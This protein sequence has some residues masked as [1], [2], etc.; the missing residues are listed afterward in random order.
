M[1]VKQIKNYK[2][3]QWVAE[4]FCHLYLWATD[5]YAG[6]ATSILRHWGFTVKV[7]IVWIKP[8]IRMGNYFRHQHELCFFATRGNKRLKRNDLSTIFHA[9]VTIH[10]EK[11]D[12]FYSLVESASFENY[13]DI[14]ARK[15]RAGWDV[16]GN[17]IVAQ[18]QL[19]LA[20]DNNSSIIPHE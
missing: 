18:Y 16:V 3:E 4:D 7:T 14:F 2:I 6:E 8:F 11:P 10:S 19:R 12:A 1:T 20:G 17:E 13:L 9:P 15:R 5:A